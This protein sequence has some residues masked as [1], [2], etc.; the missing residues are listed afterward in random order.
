MRVKRESGIIQKGWLVRKW[1]HGF[2]PLGLWRGRSLSSEPLPSFITA[3]ADSKQANQHC[4]GR[5]GPE[6][7]PVMA[8]IAL[9]TKLLPPQQEQ[10]LW[11]YEAR[12]CMYD[13][14]LGC[15]NCFREGNIHI[16]ISGA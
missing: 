4:S 13:R 5:R 2:D 14:A 9:P 3:C 12:R 10:D 6:P 1:I 8:H 11:Q 15:T 16:I 7:G